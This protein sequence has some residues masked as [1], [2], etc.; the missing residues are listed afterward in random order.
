MFHGLG[1][2]HGSGV[3]C[4]RAWSGHLKDGD[5]NVANSVGQHS[6]PNLVDQALTKGGR[7]TVCRVG[8]DSLFFP[9][10]ISCEWT[11]P[12]WEHCVCNGQ[13]NS[14]KDENELPAAQVVEPAVK[15]S[16]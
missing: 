7:N 2:F 10:T 13:K 6:G 1:G 15:A 4:L 9:P 14:E 3:E 11:D 16:P 8:R 5:V 12:C